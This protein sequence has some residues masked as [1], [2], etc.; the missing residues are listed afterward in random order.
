MR[1]NTRVLCTYR[2]IYGIRAKQSL[3]NSGL[4]R[5]ARHFSEWTKKR[6]TEPYFLEQCARDVTG[7]DECPIGDFILSTPH[8]AV[9]CETCEELFT[10]L[11]PS[12]FAGLN[13]AEI[14]LNSSASHAE[15]RKLKQRLDLIANSTRKL[16]GVYVYANAIGVDGEA[17]MLFDGSS[18][19]IVNGEVV[20]QSSQFSLRP[21]EVTIATI[22]VEQVRSYR[23]SYSRGV[24]AAQQKEYPRIKCEIEIGQTHEEIYVSKAR[25]AKPIQ[26]KILDPMEEIYMAEAV[27]LW[28]Y[29]TRTNSPGFFL[30]LSG[31]LDSC[32]VSLFVYGLARLVLI[33]IN[34][35]ENTTL[36]DLRRVTGEPDFTPKT[37]QDIVSRLL[38]TCYMGTVNSSD[39]TQSRAKKLA[40]IIGAYH[41]NIT[42]DEAV[43]AFEIIAG[44]A[45]TG[46]QPKYV[47]DGGSQSESLAKQNIQARSRMVVAYEIAQ[48]ST[49]A[50]K[51]PRQGASLLVL[52]SGNVD[53]NLRGYFTKYDASS[54]DL[55]PLGSISKND[56]K[57]FLRWAREK[58][59]LPILTQFL[60]ATPTAEL[61]P[62]SAGVQNDEDENEMGM[63]YSELSGKL[64]R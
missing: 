58:W 8:T 7:Q 20:A 16:G 19:I 54:A 32:S 59:D 35:G 5:E 21:V 15:L 43:S 50:R 36:E 18:M 55:A 26:L 12:S 9:A 10:P 29:L 46:F 44:K 34:K 37:P 4:Y 11:N 47:T 57:D 30:A 17:R 51:T 1:Y 2:H 24:Q 27:Y 60:D 48:L 28:Q 25:I 42:I 61:L 23:S 49:T 41:S 31:G 53:E 52:G 39:E 38:H 40:G 45:L 56:A 6:T 14:I 13:G 22:D 63:T 3:A 64:L 33:S 62:L